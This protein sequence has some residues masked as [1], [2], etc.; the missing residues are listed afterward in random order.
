MSKF[1]L[2]IFEDMLLG[3]FKFQNL[4]S[5][6][7]LTFYHDVVI[8]FLSNNA[9]CIICF[10]RYYCSYT[11]FLFV[12]FFECLL[13]RQKVTI[14]SPWAWRAGSWEESLTEQRRCRAESL[15]CC[16]FPSLVPSASQLREAQNQQVTP[17]L[18][19][20]SWPLDAPGRGG[21]S[22]DTLTFHT[23]IFTGL[24]S[25]SNCVSSG[26]WS[27]FGTT[28]SYLQ[29]LAFFRLHREHECKTKHLKGWMVVT[30]SR[31]RYFSPSLFI[32]KM[33]TSRFLCCPC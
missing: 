27:S 3:T 20:A 4:T 14:L 29:L 31:G 32:A 9:Y 5:F 33:K 22:N 18:D 6:G 2:H 21:G 19:E 8:L 15:A 1:A 13:S 26:I 28:W 17:R 24:V 10:V 23:V 30:N 25:I 12:F 11:L 16:P 7:E